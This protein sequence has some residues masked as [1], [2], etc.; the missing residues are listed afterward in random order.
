MSS[1]ISQVTR[2][3]TDELYRKLITYYEG[4]TAS[5]AHIFSAGVIITLSSYV[6]SSEKFFKILEDI[7]KLLIQ[8]HHDSN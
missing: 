7:K 5:E 6:E 2:D 1:Q 4:M 3:N 8:H